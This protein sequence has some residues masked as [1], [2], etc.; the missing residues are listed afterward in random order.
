MCYQDGHIFLCGYLDEYE[1]EV[2][3]IN[4]P[5]LS[6]FTPPTLSPSLD[7]TSPICHPTGPHQRSK[8]TQ[9]ATKIARFSFVDVLMSIKGFSLLLPYHPL[10]GMTPISHPTG[11]HQRPKSTQCAREI[12]RFPFVDILMSIKGK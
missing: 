8:S 4:S 10:D 12:V 3:R 11:P 1:G 6:F 5:T 2:T 9:R 7:G